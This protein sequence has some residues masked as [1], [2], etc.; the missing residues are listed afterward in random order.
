MNVHEKFACFFQDKN[1][2]PFAF[3]LSKKL[4]EG[5]ICINRKKQ[6]AED[7]KNSIYEDVDFCWESLKDCKLIS[8]V[9]ESRKP[10]FME[11]DKLYLYRYYNYEKKIVEKLKNLID[12][13]NSLAECRKQKL[14]SENEF[15]KKLRMDETGH[16]DL[17]E[18]EKTDWQ[19]TAC[20]N[21]FLHN[22]SIITGGPG[23][24][25][26]TTVAKLLAL[27]FRENKQLKVALAA[28]TG[29]AG[30]RIQESLRNS[31]E[32]NDFFKHS[33]LKEMIEN[34]KSFTIHR[35]L[36][37]RHNSPYFR[38][39]EDN[40]LNYDVIIVDEASMIDVP[41]FCKLLSAVNP[42]SRIIL[43]GD[44]EQ[45]ASVEAGSLFGDLC[46]SIAAMNQFSD[47][48]IEFFNGFLSGNS[49]ISANNYEP[50]SEL[51][52]QHIVELKR[53]YRAKDSPEIINLSK[54]IIE[55]DDDR[56]K[57]FY[58]INY[59]AKIIFEDQSDHLINEYINNIK[60]YLNKTCIKEALNTLKNSK[61]LC[62]VKNGP[63]GVYAINKKI[64]QILSKSKNLKTNKLFYE[65]RPVMITK[66][67]RDLELFNGDIGIIRGGE[68]C[69]LRTDDSIYKVKPALIAECETVFA[70][71]IHKSQGSEYDNVFIILPDKADNRILTK[72]L[73]Y[74]AVTR[75]K[76]QVVVLAKEEVIK[77]TIN[78]SVNRASGIK[79]RLK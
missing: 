1:I 21:S 36:G 66:N 58:N 76:K 20:I 56:V 43:L 14:T 48:N 68:A 30:V 78:K 33:V 12:A 55:E 27:L 52:C 16:S 3:L 44:K 67:Y 4:S 37:Y 74:T 5:H 32:N 69:F 73:L 31:V 59:P 53:S 71:S 42:L 15:I 26:T 40:Y 2:Q 70:M 63:R 62:A 18:D 11:G 10:F 23:T 24:G 64:E 25:K 49:N 39:D 29:K 65:N 17:V 60:E 79:E 54:G 6:Y 51:L 13:G 50:S 34:C 75:A 35:L 57:Q 61:I 19:L 45:L 8:T 72:E 38:H 46:K 41:M 9:S 28:P 7:L 77:S 47:E 22:F